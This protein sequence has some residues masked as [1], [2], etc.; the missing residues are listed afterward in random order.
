MCRFIESIQVLDGIFK[1]LEFHQERIRK[2]MTDYY[3][4]NKIIRI[5][6]ALDA[7]SFPTE[8]LYKCRVIYDFEIRKIEFVPY[9]TREIH[10]LKLVETHMESTPYKMEDRSRLNAA[11]ALRGDCDEIIMIKN[12][13]LTDTSF[14]NIALY[15]GINWVTPRIPLIYGV[16]RAQLVKEGILTE[17]DINSSDLV[18]FKRVSLFNAMNEFGSLEL[19]IS[20]IRH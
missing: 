19:D 7:A 20:S 8:G 11:F 6:E 1:R 17:K 9:R 15:D 13:W 3:P 14:S 18:N 10:S 5:A 16:T 12:G 4:T 2:A